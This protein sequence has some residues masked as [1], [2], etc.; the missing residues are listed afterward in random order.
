MDQK[1]ERGLQSSEGVATAGIGGK[2]SLELLSCLRNSIHRGPM[3]AAQAM[4]GRRHA[5][6]LAPANET[7]ISLT[8]GKDKRGIE[9][10]CGKIH[11][12]CPTRSEDLWG[13]KRVSGEKDT[14][15]ADPQIFME[16]LLFGILEAVE[17]TLNQIVPEA[18]T[19]S[20]NSAIRKEVDAYMLLQ[21]LFPRPD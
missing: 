20:S 10:V 4:K 19:N 7:L 2:D 1:V 5:R 13:I 6:I 16:R 15:L 21:Q 9:R 11:Q 12:I 8:G 14:L 17:K 18:N 3:W